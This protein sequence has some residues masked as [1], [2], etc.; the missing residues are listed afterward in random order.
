MAHLL[1]SDADRIL[2]YCENP[3]IIERV[4]N[5]TFHDE[6]LAELARLARGFTSFYTPRS[7]TQLIA[8]GTFTPTFSGNYTINSL[9]GGGGGG[10]GSSP[11][12]T[13]LIGL[14]GGGGAAGGTAEGVLALVGGTS[15]TYTIGTAGAGGTVTAGATHNGGNGGNGGNSSFVGP[16]TILAPGGG[17]GQGGAYQTPITAVSLVGDILTCTLTNTPSPGNTIPFTA[18]VNI[19]GAAGGT[20]GSAG[21]SGA[22]INGLWQNGRANT[23][24]TIDLLY[25]NGGTVPSGTYTASSAI[26]TI[27]TINGGVTGVST[28][29]L[30][31][32]EWGAGYG[33]PAVWLQ[34]LGEISASGLGP[35]GLA[36]GG[37]GTGGSSSA[38]NGG[39]GGAGGTM[40][41]G[42][43]GGSNGG[44]GSAAGTVGTAGGTNA[45]AGGGGG[46]GAAASNAAAGG[47]GSLGLIIVEGPL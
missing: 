16:S 42:G 26:L 7:T 3:K 36:G 4:N 20:W 45:G 14:G 17:G 25:A 15:Y 41:G 5:H 37:G 8:S 47:A 12:T 13:A 9:G 31:G 39:T 22:G 35:I 43:L 38:S 40:A 46:G 2:Y 30:Y 32:A 23:G 27:L 29:S 18:P 1:R 10:A 33:A 24:T 11:A 19:A 44:S 6:K 28:F 34:G 21:S